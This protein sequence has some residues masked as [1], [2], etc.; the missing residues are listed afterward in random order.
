MFWVF[1]LLPAQFSW[2]YKAV[3]LWY[4]ADADGS[5]AAAFVL[6]ESRTSHSAPGRPLL[7]Q[8]TCVSQHYP[9]TVHFGA[10]RSWA[11]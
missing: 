10:L 8:V 2:Q 7:E 4:R 3:L 5:S 11:L 1:L 9:L 6:E